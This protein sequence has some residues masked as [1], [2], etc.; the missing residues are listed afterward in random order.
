MTWRIG[1]TGFEMTLDRRVP[2]AIAE[3]AP[4]FV[5][6]FLAQEGLS[7]AEVRRWAPH[8]GG[9]RIVSAVAEALG[10][11]DAATASS[12]GVLSDCGNMSSATIFFVLERELAR[13]GEGP[14]VAL[15][16]GPG[17][18]MEAALFMPPR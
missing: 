12:R 10:L 8:P 1:D 15:G 4:G 7:R 3:H 17:L 9:R 18:T 11:D 6:G 5:D 14:L 2:D 13:D 16:F